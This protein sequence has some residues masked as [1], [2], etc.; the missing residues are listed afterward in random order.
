MFSSVL[1]CIEQVSWQTPF[2]EG[3]HTLGRWGV[4]HF[5]PH[6]ETSEPDSAHYAGVAE[7]ILRHRM[8]QS[9]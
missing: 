9:H 8:L 3:H 6:V 2:S 5:E 4:L 1:S 7:T